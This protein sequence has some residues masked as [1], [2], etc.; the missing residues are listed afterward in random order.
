MQNID[1]QLLANFICTCNTLRLKKHSKT[2]CAT[3][4]TS[5]KSETGNP[6]CLCA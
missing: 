4:F 3:S 6:A 1:L 2:C 5:L